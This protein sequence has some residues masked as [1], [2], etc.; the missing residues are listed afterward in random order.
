MQGEGVA[1]QQLWELLLVCT[2]SHA[3]RNSFPL[4]KLCWNGAICRM[5]SGK[6]SRWVGRTHLSA[7]CSP[8]L[9]CTKRLKK[10]WRVQAGK[11]PPIFCQNCEMWSCNESPPRFYAAVSL[12]L[13]A[14]S[15]MELCSVPSHSE[16]RIPFRLFACSVPSFQ[17][18][19]FAVRFS[20]WCTVNIMVLNEIFVRLTGSVVCRV[21]C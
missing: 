13:S 16:C 6:R 11:W 3:A 5:C 18:L 9:T 8:F 2:S 10:N 7:A 20:L 15:S 21:R 4:V 19:L 14:T 12:I 17:K 1:Q